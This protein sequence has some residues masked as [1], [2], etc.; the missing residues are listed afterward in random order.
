MFCDS[1]PFHDFDKVHEIGDFHSSK[2]RITR[3]NT[4]GKIS[5]LLKVFSMIFY[6]KSRE[7]ILT[8]PSPTTVNGM[9]QRSTLCIK[10]KVEPQTLQRHKYPYSETI[11]GLTKLVVKF[12]LN[13]G[14]SLSISYRNHQVHSQLIL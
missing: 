14:T 3:K 6:V 10:R 7:L 1:C 4:S 12:I 5:G 8:R 11:N 2:R 9:T 13:R